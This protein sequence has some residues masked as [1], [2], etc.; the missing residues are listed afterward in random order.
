MNKNSATHLNKLTNHLFREH[1]GKMVSYLCQKYGYHQIEDILDAVQESFE[2]AL[3]TWRFSA[4]PNSPFAWLCKVASNKLLNKIKR[5]NLSKNYLNQISDEEIILGQYSEKEAED[6]LL[7]LLIFFSTADFTER[8]KLVISLYYL[9][10]FN[11]AEIANGLFLQIDNVKKIISRSTSVIQKYAGHY[12][13]FQIQTIDQ[14]NHLLKVIYLLFNEGYKSSQAKGA[15]NHDL[16][17]EAFRLAKLLHRYSPSNA[18]TSALLAAM[19]FHSSRFPARMANQTWISLAH[20]DRSLWDSQLISNGFYYLRMARN[21]QVSLDK[22]YL[23]ALISSL[24]CSAAT[25]EETDWKTIA[26]LYHQLEHTTPNSTTIT[27][28]R[29]IAESNFKELSPLLSELDLMKALITKET[30][31]FYHSTK[32]HLYCKLKAWDLALE[33]NNLSLAYAKN[34]TDINFIHTKIELIKKNIG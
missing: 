32:A 15:I 2:A 31:F 34:K 25:Y 22:Y 20:Q 6:S 9:C 12:D 19:C 11:Y 16:C 21:H 14:P 29:I 18:K 7:K 30:A 27:L 8:N 3:K 33:N 23:E 28:N 10:G 5:A 17:F 26:Y 4:I 1:Y 13:D 24:H